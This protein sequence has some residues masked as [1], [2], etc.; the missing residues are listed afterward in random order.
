MTN[1]ELILFKITIGLY[2]VSTLWLAGGFIFNREKLRNFFALPVLTA[3]A[4]HTAVI[5]V[6]WRATG[7]GPVMKDYENALLGAWLTAVL[8]L[9]LVFKRRETAVIGIVI[10]PFTM[11]LLGF[12][13][14][15]EPVLEPLSP[16]YKSFWLYVHVF[17]AWL[18]FGAYAIAFGFAVAFFMRGH[19]DKKSVQTKIPELSALDL[20][21]FRIILFGFILHAVMIAAGS[22]WAAKL[23]GSYWSWDPIETWSLISWL[24]YGIV[25]H[26]RMTFAWKNR[27]FAIMIMLA[28]VT[29]IIAWLGIN[30]IPSSDHVFSKLE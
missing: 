22:I 10:M 27:K 15:A 20:T 24:C 26:L 25:I 7:H 28:L 18:A 13:F 1:A 5:I 8:Y 23:W 30:W 3:L 11:L 14:M 12:A 17:T 4:A 21:A 29:V 2:L 19:Y 9:L 6:R 16:G